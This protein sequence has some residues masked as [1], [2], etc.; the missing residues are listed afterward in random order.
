MKGEIVKKRL[1]DKGF[2]LS[3]IAATIGKTP[4]N[5]DGQLKSDDVK[6]GLLENIAKAV[7][8]GMD[9][10]Y[11][12]LVPVPKDDVTIL[13]ENAYLKQITDQQKETID[14]QKKLV[15]SLEKRIEELELQLQYKKSEIYNLKKANVRQDDNADYADAK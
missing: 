4:Q 3:D 2:V 1:R 14:T 12:D 6:S 7:G 15:T 5:F 11:D 13:F 8:Y 9:L 10:F